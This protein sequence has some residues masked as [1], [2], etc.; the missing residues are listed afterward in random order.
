MDI[1]DFMVTKYLNIAKNKREALTGWYWQMLTIWLITKYMKYQRQEF[2]LRANWPHVIKDGGKIS[3]YHIISYH[4]NAKR[5]A[6]WRRPPLLE[7][8]TDQLTS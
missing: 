8:M 3:F 1:F 2:N 5:S 4:F 6:W 7:V